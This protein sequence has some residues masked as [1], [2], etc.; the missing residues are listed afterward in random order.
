MSLLFWRHRSPSLSPTPAPSTHHELPYAPSDFPVHRQTLC[1]MASTW[2]SRLVETT[3]YLHS[4]IISWNPSAFEDV[5]LALS[6][7]KLSWFSQAGLSPTHG[8]SLAPCLLVTQVT[9]P[10]S[11]LALLRQWL[12]R[13]LSLCR[14]GPCAAHAQEGACLHREQRAPIVLNAA[15]AVW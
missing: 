3:Y 8:C 5:F 1:V 12:P 10:C 7:G 13:E 11:P 2:F 9:F 15:H 4:P 6:A 14:T